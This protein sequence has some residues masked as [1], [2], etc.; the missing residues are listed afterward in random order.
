MGSP[1]SER[2]RK[3][4]PDRKQRLLTFLDDIVF[5]FSLALVVIAALAILFVA[6]Q[7]H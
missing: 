6:C 4:N 3:L 5:G 1:L 2:E 7:V